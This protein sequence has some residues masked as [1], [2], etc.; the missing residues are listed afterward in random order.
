[1]SWIDYQRE[2]TEIREVIEEDIIT[3]DQEQIYWNKKPLV[4]Y[5]FEEIKRKAL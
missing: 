2:Y 5:I 4:E 3:D 1:M